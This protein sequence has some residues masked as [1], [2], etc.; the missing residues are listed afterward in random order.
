[1]GDSVRSIDRSFD[2]LEMPYPSTIANAPSA[3]IV[4]RQTSPFAPTY[5]KT[6]VSA[7]F[8]QAAIE[9]ARAEKRQ[10]PEVRKEG[11][12]KRRQR[13][14]VITPAERGRVTAVKSGVRVR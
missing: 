2:I 6:T 4:L 1:M 5:Q 9:A 12:S 7:P 8:R 10:S 13:G 11:H 14:S 3:P